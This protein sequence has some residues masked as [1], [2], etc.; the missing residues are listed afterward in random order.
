MIRILSAEVVSLGMN[1]DLT[2]HEGC[3]RLH[4]R[5]ADA[6][7][8]F[9]AEVMTSI[10]GTPSVERTV[11]EA[12]MVSKAVGQVCDGLRRIDSNAV[13]IFRELRE[14]EEAIG[15]AVPSQSRKSALYGLMGLRDLPARL[16]G[17][18]AMQHA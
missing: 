18:G 3:V 1:A 12:A 6:D 16:R 9:T 7:A 8:I 17:T 11:I 14:R 10:P 4:Y 2:A 13:N 5:T 15:A